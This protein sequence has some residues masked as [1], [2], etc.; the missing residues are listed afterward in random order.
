[1]LHVDL[2]APIAKLLDR[3]AKERPAQVAYWDSSR[4]ITYAQLDRST[5]A[6]AANLAKAGVGQGDRIAIYLPNGVDWIE[7]CL[8]GLRAGAVIVPISFDAAEGEISYRLTDASCGRDDA[9]QEGLGRED[10]ARR[11]N[12]TRSV[13]CRPRRATNRPGHG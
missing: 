4:S 5:A 6:I 2:I 12:F 11:R 8:A 13:L 3:H 9:G 1:M 10:L 7:A